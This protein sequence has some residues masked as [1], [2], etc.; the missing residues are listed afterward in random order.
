MRQVG[1]HHVRATAG[2]RDLFGH[3]VEL[4]L[5]PRRNHYVSAGLC[6]CECHCRA[7]AAARAG[8]DGDLAVEFESVE[9][10]VN[11]RY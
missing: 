5:R 3:L 8:D 10:H 6:E 11:R 2:G 4:R 9:D 7:E 1:D